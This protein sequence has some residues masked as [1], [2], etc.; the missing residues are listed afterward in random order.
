[1]LL[2]D[3]LGNLFRASS[4]DVRS[5]IDDFIGGLLAYETRAEGILAAAQA[6]PDAVLAQ[7]FAGWLWMFLESPQGPPQARPFLLA[8]ERALNGQAAAD[9]ADAGGAGTPEARA[10]AE[11][12]GRHVKLLAHWVDGDVPGA[13]READAL[14]ERFPRDLVVVKLRQYFAFNRGDS[15]A[16]LRAILRV[17]P[18]HAE[19]AYAHGMA[20]FAYEQCHLL[21]EAEAAARRALALRLDE[22]EPWAQHAL[23]HV[24]LTQ[25]RIEEGTRLL[26]G[27]RPGW[28]GLNSFMS[29][30][31][32]W[33][34]AL[35]HLARGRD[36]EALA[37]YDDAVW[38]VSTSY[39]QDQAG[40]VQLLAR[41]EWCGV[42]VGDRWSE[43]AGFI[44]ARGIDTVEPFLTLLYLYGLARAARPEADALLAAVREADHGRR[45]VWADVVWPAAIGLVAHARGEPERAWHPLSQALPG[46][47]H[48]GGSH[49]QRDLFALLH[50]DAAT[51]AGALVDAQQALESRRRVDPDEVAVNRRLAGLYRQLDLPTLAEAAQERAARVTA[52]SERLKCSERSERRA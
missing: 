50:V 42:D 43:L 12:E 11:R 51:H 10:A 13:Q 18:V 7:V 15:P 1:M 32:A 3:E 38:G 9:A 8:A 22:R 37:L 47:V 25:G 45:D 6:H 23:A 36:A 44:A 48:I 24:L 21:E 28:T 16:M 2:N 41:L 33:H 4:A 27:W 39:S 40:A 52:E 29:T 26:E 31:L 5:G 30:H 34:L 49:A 35:F 17:L 20:A 46:L 19:N 14:I